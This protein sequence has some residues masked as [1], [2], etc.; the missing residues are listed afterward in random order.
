MNLMSSSLGSV[1]GCVRL[2]WSWFFQLLNAMG[3]ASWFIT[4]FLGLFVLSRFTD[5]VLMQFLYSPT[6]I[7]ATSTKLHAV[8]EKW[9]K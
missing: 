2:A 8:K 4:T 3:G 7:D 1:I 6:S 9:S 5:L